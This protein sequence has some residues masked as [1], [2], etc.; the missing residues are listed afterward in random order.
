MQSQTKKKIKKI[1]TAQLVVLIILIIDFVLMIVLGVINGANGPFPYLSAALVVLGLVE[2]FLAIAR[3]KTNS[4]D[5]YVKAKPANNHSDGYIKPNPHTYNNNQ[6]EPKENKEIRDKIWQFDAFARDYYSK[7]PLDDFSFSDSDLIDL[8]NEVS[9]GQL[10]VQTLKPLVDKMIKHLGQTF[11]F[12][13]IQIVRVAPGEGNYAGYVEKNSHCITVNYDGA[14]TYK[15]VLALLAHEVSHLYQFYEFTK[16]PNEG[17]ETEEFTDFLTFY[18]GFGS[19]VENGYTYYLNLE[20][21]RT[22]GYLNAYGLSFAKTTLKARREMKKIE[23][24]D[25]D[26]MVVIKDRADQI[27]KVIPE[28]YQIIESIIENLNHC[29]NIG[30]DDLAEIGRNINLFK[31][32]NLHAC[33]QTNIT[34]QKCKNLTTIQTLEKEI[35]KYAKQIFDLYSFFIQM[36]EKYR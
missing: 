6:E 36:N 24:E 25:N 19:F 9:H 23:K 32:F 34:I 26:K 5:G 20:T 7:L 4:N 29:T 30:S 18:L 13:S 15:A 27:S 3:R 33:H 35:Q 16:Y 12:A 28:Y 31:Q 21:K 11:N 22:L 10:T 17:I 8:K 14:M 2:L 1:K